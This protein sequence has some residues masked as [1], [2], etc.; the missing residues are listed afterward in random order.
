MSEFTANSAIFRPRC[1]SWMPLCKHSAGRI[2][3]EMA[4][5]LMKSAIG[6]SV[7][8]HERNGRC[9]DLPA[10]SQ[11]N[12]GVLFTYPVTYPF[13]T[14]HVAAASSRFLGWP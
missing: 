11:I 8:R 10:T 6:K 14:S 3:V 9:A 2:C 1:P 4:E 12:T 5:L 13:F 7:H